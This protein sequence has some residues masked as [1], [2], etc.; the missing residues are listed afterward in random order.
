MLTQST[1]SDSSWATSN[2][3]NSGF[4]KAIADA[5]GAPLLIS[6]TFGLNSP[7]GLDVNQHGN[8]V[9]FHSDQVAGNS[10]VR[11]MYVEDI[12]ESGNTVTVN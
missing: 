7:G 1:F 2:T 11:M 4:V 12:T 9:A 8:R 10:D 5:G 6:S 3:V